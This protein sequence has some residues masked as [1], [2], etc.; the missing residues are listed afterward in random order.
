[1]AQLR[2]RGLLA[3]V[4]CTE[5]F[6]PLGKAAAAVFKVPDL[7]LIVIDHPLGGVTFD[8]VKARAAQALPKLV[9]LLHAHARF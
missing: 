3:A 4:I 9:E 2:Q 6:V 8:T 7:P 1:M 5:N